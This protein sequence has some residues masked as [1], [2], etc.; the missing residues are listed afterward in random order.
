MYVT[1]AFLLILILFCFLKVKI[2]ESFSDEN[3]PKATSI[4]KNGVLF[5]IKILK[6]GIY[7]PSHWNI[8]LVTR[9]KGVN[10]VPAKVVWNDDYSFSI[11]ESGQDYILP[12]EVVFVPKKQIHMSPKKSK[13]KKTENVPRWNDIS[14]PVKNDI[15][16]VTS[17][18]V[19]QSSYA[20][21]GLENMTQYATFSVSP[22]GERILEWLYPIE[23][24]NMRLFY[25]TLPMIKKKKKK[26][27]A[28]YMTNVR[29]YNENGAEIASKNFSVK[30]NV[31]VWVNDYLIKK[32][33]VSG[34]MN[35]NIEVNGRKSTWTCEEY[36]DFVDQLKESK[37]KAGK[38]S[39]KYEDDDAT[40]V[41]SELISQLPA[42]VQGKTKKQYI[43][44]YSR[45]R[46]N[47]SKKT[48]EQIDVERQL[49]A[50]KIDMYRQQI[51]K[52]VDNQ[53]KYRD[54]LIKDYEKMVEQYK[55]DEIDAND[56]KRFGI[57]P[58]EFMYS[59]KEIDDL[60]KRIERTSNI[61]DDVLIKNCSSLQRKY[62]SQRKKA[63]KW[64]KAAIFVPF[65]KKKAKRES[66]KAEKTEKKYETECSELVSL[67]YSY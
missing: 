41:Y 13:D 63:E 34:Y 67:S 61:P 10:Y 53:Y 52:E 1:I 58:P 65:L 66:K 21:Y 17:D 54:K 24:Q 7:K 28:R 19:R 56:A 25:D 12:P 45:Y 8:T 26:F 9:S 49:E 15:Q 11:L 64:A 33:V 42:D 22:Q 4:L 43:K 6:K 23:F 39:S 59:K 16:D 20:D 62:E 36:T 46:D 14:L 44:L 35:S 48:K 3:L 5:D 37:N 50:Q 55:M 47:C 40:I 60:R 30:K 57:S 27:D 29:L 51:K 38:P 31:L 18:F 32:I 2:E